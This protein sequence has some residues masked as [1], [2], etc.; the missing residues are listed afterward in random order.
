MNSL[1]ICLR[2]GITGGIGSGKTTVC[3]IFESIGVP[4]Y[5]ADA[6]AKKLIVDDPNIRQGLIALLGEKTYRPD[7]S[8]NRAW[9]AEQVFSAPQ[10]LQALNQLVHPAVG[11]HSEAWHTQKAAEG[12]PYT[13][14]EAALLIESGDYRN[15]DAI[16]LV[17]ASENTRLQ[18][19]MARDGLS[20]EQVKARMERQM[21]ETEK[22]PFADFTID[23]EG[24]K[25][26]LQQIW[27]VHQA[28]LRK[29][30]E[31]LNTLAPG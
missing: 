27:A 14:K 6:E 20:Q 25:S 16:I 24:N 8:Y 9:V 23:N 12:H 10:K 2:A 22:A 28:L 30:K 18:R 7:G 19:V 17:S 11:R 1:K 3:R 29:Q 13:L 15:M 21:P 5:Y 31:A 26:L 4:V